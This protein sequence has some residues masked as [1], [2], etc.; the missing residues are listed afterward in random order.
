MIP[1]K[2]RTGNQARDNPCLRLTTWDSV[3]RFYPKTFDGVSLEQPMNPVDIM[4]KLDQTFRYIIERTEAKLSSGEGQYSGICP[5]HDDTSPSLSISIQQG[6]ILLFCHTGCDI[7]QILQELGIKMQDLFESSPV[8]SPILQNKNEEKLKQMES[9][10]RAKE[11]WDQIT[12]ATDDHPYLL[13]K[14]VQNHG[15][16]QSE[17]Q[18]VVPLYDQDHVLQSLQFKIGRASCRERV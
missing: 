1:P 12:E 16:K 8:G 15:L 4:N 11:I 3:S 13:N 9:R 18:V 2:L 6:Q 10:S 14:K 7:N 5:A 17:G